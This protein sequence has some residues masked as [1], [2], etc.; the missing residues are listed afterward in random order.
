[1]SCDSELKEEILSLLVPYGQQSVLAHSGRMGAGCAAI[2]GGANPRARSGFARPSLSG[3]GQARR[4]P[5]ACPPRRTSA[6]LPL[7][8]STQS[9]H[10]ARGPASRP[11]RPPGRRRRGDARRGRAGDP[12]G[13]PSSQGDV[14]HRARFRAV[15]VS[16]SRRE[17]SGRWA[18]VRDANSALPDDQPGDPRRPSPS[19]PPTTASA[20]P[21]KT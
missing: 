12:V 11:R 15:A 21:R 13:V 14:F 16:D 5:R 7:E 3:T 20:W 8:Q 1:M 2:L 10:A 4:N 9:L 19:S 18:A 6:G 17:D